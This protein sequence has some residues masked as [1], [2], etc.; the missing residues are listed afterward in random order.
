[1]SRLIKFTTDSF[2]TEERAAEVEKFF[3]DNKNPAERVVMQSVE[4]I[5]LNA[6]WLERDREAIKAFLKA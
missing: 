3:K 4:N 1:M 2:A 5:R 6:S